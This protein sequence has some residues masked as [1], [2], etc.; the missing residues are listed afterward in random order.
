MKNSNFPYIRV[1]TTYYKLI[2]RP[3]ISGDKV[4]TLAK[5]SRDTIIQDY[6]RKNIFAK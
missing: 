6:K 2:E 5:W 4:A 3:Q 1:D